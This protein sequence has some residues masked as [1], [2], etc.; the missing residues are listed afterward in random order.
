MDEYAILDLGYHGITM[1]MYK[2]DQHVA[3]REFDVGLSSLEDIVAD[4]FGVEKH[5]A[6]TYIY[7][8]FENCLESDEC[9]NFYDNIVVEL[10]RAINF[11]GF[12]NQ[13]SSLNDLWIC[14]GGAVNEPLIRAIYDTLEME[15]HSS[16]ELVPGGDS[17]DHY[18]IYVQAIG[19]TLE[20]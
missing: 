20:I 12:S 6:H 18:N 8:N 19:V 14:G 11:Y 15:L 10:E 17:V 4:K 16:R 13:D 2:G 1:Y 9:V 5:L 3:T 7:N